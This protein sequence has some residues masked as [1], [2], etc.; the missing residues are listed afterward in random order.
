MEYLKFIPEGWTQN[1]ENANL[2]SIKDAYNT[3]KIMQGLVYDC[4]SNFNLHVKLGENITGIIPRNEIDYTNCD[5]YGYT[6]PSI[7]K[8]KLN[9]YVQF[10]VKE[11][12]SNNQIILSRKNANKEALEWMNENLEPGMIVKG[13]VKNI[14]NY[15]VFV[16]IGAGVT[17]AFT[18]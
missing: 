14:R 17:R 4:D 9:S 13:I 18:Y 11:I 10:K 1:N 15:G 5:E 12:Y 2:E 7:I 6:K 16:E 8:N 3:G